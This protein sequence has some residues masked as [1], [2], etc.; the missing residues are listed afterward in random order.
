M[1]CVYLLC[2]CAFDPLT[3][4]KI[5]QRTLQQWIARATLTTEETEHVLA[6]YT[7]S[8]VCKQ[9][10]HQDAVPSQEEPLGWAHSPSTAW[11]ALFSTLVILELGRKR[12]E[13]ERFKV[14][15]P[16]HC[17]QKRQWN[18]TPVL[19]SPVVYLLCKLRQH[20]AGH[21]LT[22]PLIKPHSR[23]RVNKCTMV[24]IPSPGLPHARQALC[25][26]STSLPLLHWDQVLSC[27]PC[28]Y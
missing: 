15:L 14:I 19:E 21:L 20:I 10:D 18:K 1:F 13:G 27:K 12:R 4:F 22:C 9:K 16:L 3:I 23:K 2:C 28:C 11:T 5:A 17:K 24:A 25:H 8:Q 6:S 7:S 26:S